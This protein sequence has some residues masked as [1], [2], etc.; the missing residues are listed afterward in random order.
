MSE[1]RPAV[2]SRKA[3]VIIVVVCFVLVLLGTFIYQIG[4]PEFWN[5]WFRIAWG[6]LTASRDQ[7]R[8]CSALNRYYAAHGEYPPYLLGG[9]AQ[10]LKQHE[11]RDPLLDEAYLRNYPLWVYFMYS[12]ASAAADPRGLK[13]MRNVVSSRDDPLV[14]Y[15]RE[16][17]SPY[18]EGR[19]ASGLD[20]SDFAHSWQPHRHLWE[21]GLLLRALDRARYL[22]GGGVSI[23]GWFSGEPNP[24]DDGYRRRP[25]AF[26]YD[27]SAFVYPVLWCLTWLDGSASVLFPHYNE[28]SGQFGYQRGDFIEAIDGTAKDAWLWFYGFAG[29]SARTAEQLP[30]M[31]LVDNDDGLIQP[32]GIPDGIVVLYKL[33]EGKVIEVVKKYD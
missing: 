9:E 4:P 3:G 28:V 11:L 6:K 1:K 19:A 32:D 25:R 5:Q 14:K 12:P 22:C 2:R 20:D 18:L 13:R 27:T 16:L 26:A 17:E 23:E 8:L 21:E 31:D 7:R 29:W 33:K 24:E 30:G 10:E 15:Y